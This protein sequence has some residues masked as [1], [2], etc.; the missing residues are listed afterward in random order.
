MARAQH[1]WTR[2]ALGRRAGVSPDT[3]RRLE[4]GDPGVQLGTLCSVGA[5]LGLDI[6]IQAYPGRQP[7]L[8]DTGQLAV[9]RHLMDL[10][11]GS[12]RAEMEVAAG[13]NGEAVDI[14]F[15]GPTEIIDA[16]IE[17]LILDLQ[18]QYRRAAQKRDW[19]A[20]Q[21][22]R[23]VRLVMVIEDTRRNREAVAEHAELIARLLPAGTRE[24][25]RSLTTGRPLGRDGLLWIRRRR[26]SRRDPGIPAT[27]LQGSASGGD[28]SVDLVPELRGGRNS[29]MHR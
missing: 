16:E 18:K 24:I 22:R 4:A 13:R 25:L 8:R 5:A 17:R 27:P 20:G 15:F 29:P 26:T 9:A 10:A 28:T 12:W 19:L 21:H 1:G 11:H 3:V 7:A 2:A 23:P 6:V 14:G